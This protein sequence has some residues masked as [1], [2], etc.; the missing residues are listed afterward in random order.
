M[1][2][3]KKI[4]KNTCIAAGAAA[5][6][7]FAS[8]AAL[9]AGVLSRWGYINMKPDEY[10]A[11]DYNM[12]KYLDNEYFRNADD[13][14]VANAPTETKLINVKGETLHAEL[15]RQPE[16]SHLWAVVIHGYSSRPRGMAKQAFGFYEMGYNTLFPYM[17]GHRKSEQNHCS[18][19]YYEKH[20]I[21]SWINYI[22]S[23]DPESQ[24]VI[25][26]E[27]MG[28]ATTML[29]TGEELPENVKCAIEDC[30]YTNCY[31]QFVA[32]IG[33]VAHLP[34]W[35]V[36]PANTY[37]KLVH[38]WDFRD[39]SP[40]DAVARS[41]TPTLFIHG[42]NDTFVPYE[43]MSVVYDACSAEK[44]IISIPDA[45]HAEACDVHP[46]LYWP[47]IKE[48]VSKYVK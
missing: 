9:H 5:G 3:L 46:E 11:E 29:V 31:D 23:I 38:G 16:E 20:D 18:M 26:G 43:M 39:C 2:K 24:I 1:A 44:D 4:V 7:Y 14:Y 27:S 42:E 48:F 21:V 32:Q 47:K 35:F 8:G 33:N 13:W 22:A 36:K 41:K 34:T 25:I 19:G 15:I 12:Q 10:L 6:A 45:E 37:S 30:G 40:V 17:R 28:A